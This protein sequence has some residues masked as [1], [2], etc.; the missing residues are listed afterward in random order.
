MLWWGELHNY[1]EEKIKKSKFSG[2]AKMFPS[3]FPL[4]LG[5]EGKVVNV[6]TNLHLNVDLHGALYGTL[7]GFKTYSYLLCEFLFF[8]SK[9][10]LPGWCFLSTK[11]RNVSCVQQRGMQQ[12]LRLQILLWYIEVTYQDASQTWSILVHMPH[13]PHMPHEIWDAMCYSQAMLWLCLN[14]FLLVQTTAVTENMPA[15]GMMSSW[16]CGIAL[17]PVLSS[18]SG[19]YE[20]LPIG[21]KE[22]YALRRC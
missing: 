1:H 8:Q 7:D 22:K 17:C 4:F 13:M 2:V 16:I 20:K 12:S 5:P 3:R 14:N 19:N 10:W 6:H 18:I 9:Y 15:G 11:L 21:L